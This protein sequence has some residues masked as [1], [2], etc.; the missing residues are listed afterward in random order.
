MMYK[1]CP[2]RHIWYDY[3]SNFHFWHGFCQNEPSSSHVKLVLQ[4]CFIKTYKYELTG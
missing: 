1:E 2:E 3:F 4:E